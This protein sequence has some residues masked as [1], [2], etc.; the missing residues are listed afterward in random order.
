MTPR[1]GLGK[2][3]EKLA[4][5]RLLEQG[6]RILDANFRTRS[7]EIDLVTEQD[8][9]IAFVEVRARRGSAF[10]APEES[11]TR[12]KLARMVAC[13]HEYLA[14]R[15]WVHRTWRIDLVA[16]EMDARGRLLRVDV[17]ENAVDW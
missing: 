4:R 12:R 7:G 16:V 5:R 10:G 13:A 8:G 17:I 2:A 14:Q 1:Q 6:R 15:G 3:G 11:L 9:E